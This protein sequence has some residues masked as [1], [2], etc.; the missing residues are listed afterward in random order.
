MADDSTTQTIRIVI[1]ASAAKSGADD[2]K[3]SLAS[4]ED[5]VTGMSSG[6]AGAMGTIGTAFKALVA[7]A[8]L[9]K[10]VQSVESIVDAMD[11]LQRQSETL[12]V[13]TDWLQAFQAAAASSGVKI[14]E[15]TTALNKFASVVGNAA[16]GNQKAVN[17]MNDLGIKIYDAAGQ[18][19]PLND[20]F[21]EAATKITG[22]SD[23]SKVN[24]LTMQSM[25]RS[26]QAVIPMLE[27]ISQLSSTSANAA[28]SNVVP[29]ATVDKLSSG[30][31]V[32]QYIA[33]VERLANANAGA[34]TPETIANW[35]GLSSQWDKL[36]LQVQ[37]FAAS[38]FFTI[39][40]V[41]FQALTMTIQGTLVVLQGIISAF[42]AIKNLFD[43]NTA[44]AAVIS[45]LNAGIAQR[46]SLLQ[47]NQAFQAAGPFAPIVNFPGVD[48][49]NTKGQAAQLAQEIDAM[50][51]Q[52]DVLTRQQTS[53]G[54]AAAR[55]DEMSRTAP[56]V[57]PPSTGAIA[58][59]SRTSGV[60]LQNTLAKQL[61][62]AQ[63]GLEGATAQVGA[64]GQ[65]A[66]A[67]AAL[68]VHVKDLTEA[69]N[70]FIKTGADVK[71]IYDQQTGSITTNNAAVN[72]QV[73][74]LDKL[75]DATRVQN[76]LK[77]VILSTN[78]AKQQND[79][80]EQQL[81]LVGQTTEEIQRQAALS[82][83]A[84]Q[85]QKN[86][87]QQLADAGNQQA[88]QTIKDQTD[89]INRQYDLKTA[90]EAT[91]KSTQQWLQPFA[92]A[93]SSIQSDTTSMFQ[94]LFSGGV[95]TWQTMVDDMKSIF[96]KMLA[97]LASLAL[98]QTIVRPIV[99][100]L[101]S[102]GA[103]QSLGFAP[104]TGGFGG[105]A[106]IFNLG[107]TSG[108]APGAVGAS[109]ASTGGGGSLLG[110]L[111]N[112]FGGGSGGGLFGGISSFLSSPA[113]GASYSP[114]VAGDSADGGLSGFGGSSGL[115]ASGGVSYG[116]ALG[117]IG[118]IGMGA[119]SL[120]TGNG[121]TASTIG[122]IG[123]I[124]GGAMM[125]V[126]GLQPFGAALSLISS[127]APGLFGG[128][129]P[130]IP[131]QPPLVYG[132]G[133][134][135]FDPTTGGI[136]TGGDAVNGGAPLNSTA[137][138]IAASI[139]GLIA[140][141]GGTAV[142]GKL[143]G[144]TVAAGT[145]TTLNGSNW[146]PQNYTQANYTDPNGN[147]TRISY[148]SSQTLQQTADQLVASVFQ[149]D[150]LNGGVSGISATLK[151]VLANNT[152]TTSQDVQT[153]ITN[154]Q[155]YDDLVQGD[156][157]T[158]AE[159][160]FQSINNNMGS[161]VAWAAQMGLAIAPLQASQLQQQQDL[162]TNFMTPI[163]E[164]IKGFTDPLGAQLDSIKTAE[165]AAVKEAQ[166]M[167]DNI[168]GSFIDMAQVTTYYT[169]Q[170]TQ[171]TTQFYA[172]AVT[173]LQDAIDSMTF[174]SLS[175]GSPD[176]TL[177]GTRAA[178]M[179]DLTAAQGGDATSI[180]NLAT[181][182]TNYVTAAQKYYG[183]TQ[184]YNDVLSQVT[185][186]FNQILASI[187]SGAI[188]ANGSPGAVSDPQTNAI[189]TSNSALT[190]QVSDLLT[191]VASLTEEVQSLTS[192]MQRV[193]VSG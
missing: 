183:S 156:N 75:N 170:M 128:G 61:A 131:P 145:N 45:G 33:N 160:A 81:S 151:T 124:A 50:R 181:L 164:G 8:S 22:M 4:I 125:L 79:E 187:S 167:S 120:A 17:T 83:A 163:T 148:N 108:V 172:S 126:P 153:D 87:V 48:V 32:D 110:G 93:I 55:G 138:G 63:I 130:K 16:L 141:S 53:Q 94:T 127:F 161:I 159:Q 143:Y 7:V 132:Q 27:K 78:D 19:R 144:G 186:A 139:L 54:R 168:T 47:Q 18:V 116:G 92:G 192:Q 101:F 158:Q 1:D 3:N 162:A 88:Q 34:V 44:P 5:Q 64:A 15:A 28:N 97:E 67:V 84:Y 121:S 150:V 6:V 149:Q 46:Q 111:G 129:G 95:V 13:T 72:L 177:I 36:M 9:D 191:T 182:G 74:A 20:L 98:M 42:A 175:N 73:A 31:S 85:D 154:S 106:N 190:Q 82:K 185:D 43:Q 77:A 2:V 188:G 171:A 49:S 105:L 38:N 100:D 107:G 173:S 30:S 152:P 123:Q 137:N 118:S 10:V 133:S 176:S 189:L 109:N 59:T 35:A 157:L 99:Q 25:G 52:V 169:D 60:A 65:G 51:S 58:A 71:I 70:A 57:L 12:Q 89:Q 119:L 76:N 56:P 37:N 165:D 147:T 180:N 24:A 146:Q 174:G 166:W 122:G 62:D 142:A 113:Y 40:N 184:P 135:S 96:I 134:F 91:Q 179:A 21:A 112:L 193:A 14:D 136:V 11:K 29:Q 39:V 80:L 41:G 68:E 115:G 155:K 86:G 102:P 178:Y 23:A 66:D 104:G 114:L 90:I 117:G 69:S 103:A 26:A 140:Q